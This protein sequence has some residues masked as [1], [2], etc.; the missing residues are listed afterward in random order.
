MADLKRKQLIKALI[1]CVGDG[2][3]CSE[4]SYKAC[5]K[6]TMTC[7]YL[8]NDLLKDLES[9]LPEMSANCKHDYEMIKFDTFNITNKR[10]KKEKVKYVIRHCKKCD[11]ILFELCNED[12]TVKKRRVM[13]ND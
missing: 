5:T 8:L 4:C 11:N 6:M 2:A 10:G 12:G 13:K 1:R 9:E 7:R 3:K